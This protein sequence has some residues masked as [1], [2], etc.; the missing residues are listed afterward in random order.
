MNL[1]AGLWRSLSRGIMKMLLFCCFVSM[2][3]ETPEVYEM[4]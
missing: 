3:I 4:G 1:K 2:N